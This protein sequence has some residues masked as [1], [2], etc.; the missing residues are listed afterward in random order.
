VRASRP[1]V[2]IE[3]VKKADDDDA[4]IVRLT[5]AF[6]ARGRVQVTTAFPLESARRVDLLERDREPVEYDERSVVLDLRP[7]ELATLKLVPRR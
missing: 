6:G 4:V 2:T 5:E 3:A 1:N 7:F